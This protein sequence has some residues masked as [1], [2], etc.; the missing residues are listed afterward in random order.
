[1][2]TDIHFREQLN[3]EKHDSFSCIGKALC[4]EHDAGRV[5]D[6]K[7]IIQCTNSTCIAFNESEQTM[8]IKLN[9]LN[10]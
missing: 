3:I 4:K 8:N 10:K 5:N 6:Y 9:N 1:M 2:Q 7:N